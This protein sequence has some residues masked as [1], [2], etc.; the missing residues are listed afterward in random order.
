MRRGL[1]ASAGVVAAA[2]LCAFVFGRA[3]MAPYLAAWLAFLALP[4]GALPLVLASELAGQGGAA[5]NGFLRWML[6]LMPSAALLG[7]P[8]LL[9][10]HTLYPWV[11]HAPHGLASAW[12]TPLWFAMRGALYL[13]GWTWLC[14]AAFRPP[15]GA[16]RVGLCTGGLALHAAIATL[17]ATDWVA[18]L[19]PGLHAAGFGLLL[20]TAQ[21]GIA[22]SAGL[23]LASVKPARAALLLLLASGCWALLHTIQYLVVWSADKPGE[24]VWYIDR[25]NTL[26][27]AAVWLGVAGLAACLALQ[28]TGPARGMLAVA[29]GLVLAVHVV[30]MFWLVTPSLRQAFTVSPADLLALAGLAGAAVVSIRAWRPAQVAA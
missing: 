14:L 16:P 11:G 18:S 24:I 12:F 4:V 5:Q 8:V 10:G 25:G 28:G 26:G 15:E 17:A 23:L 29:S 3:A 30:E 6:V 13:A 20:M 9:F 21:I 22:L 1:L 19:A 7:L 27:V 2:L